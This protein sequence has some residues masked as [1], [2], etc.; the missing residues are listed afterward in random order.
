MECERLARAPRRE[1]FCLA[2]PLSAFQ[3]SAVRKVSQHYGLAAEAQPEDGGVALCCTGLTRVPSSRL[4]DVAGPARAP[5]D[6]Q[7]AGLALASA[8]ADGA[9]PRVVGVMRRSP[10]A[11]GGA[12]ARAPS[13]AAVLSVEE[14]EAAYERARQRILGADAAARS[15]GWT[16]LEQ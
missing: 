4:A 15:S 13:T 16:S 11:S 10:S 7:P 3:R 5:E 6:D 9:P 2:G 8:A 14:R 12:D 1:R